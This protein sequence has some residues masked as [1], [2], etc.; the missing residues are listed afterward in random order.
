M[1]RSLHRVC[2][3]DAKESQ[4]AQGSHARNACRATRGCRLPPRR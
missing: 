3:L 1:S 4:T 2:E